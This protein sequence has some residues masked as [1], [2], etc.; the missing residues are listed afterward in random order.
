MKVFNLTSKPLA[1]RGQV[2][3]PNGGSSDFKELDVFIS[4]R[5][6]TLVANKVIALGS[7]PAWWLRAREIAAKPQ[8]ALRL[9]DQPSVQDSVKFNRG[10]FP[11]K[12]R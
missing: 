3:A 2:L 4:D 8:T 6:N 7:L 11:S 9:V 5:D 10:F 1:Y 12:K